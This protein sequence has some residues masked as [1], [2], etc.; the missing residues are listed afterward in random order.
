MCYLLRLPPLYI[1]DA[2]AMNWV[3]VRGDEYAAE[4][5]YQANYTYTCPIFSTRG[6]F[7][8]SKT[9]KRIL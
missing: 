5:N 4:R 7:K 9:V 1:S 8:Y 2:V 3:V 6:K